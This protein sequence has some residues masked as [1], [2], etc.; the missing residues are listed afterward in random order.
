MDSKFDR[1]AAIPHFTIKQDQQLEAARMELEQVS[2]A[3]REANEMELP[4]G[5]YRVVEEAKRKELN[6]LMESFAAANLGSSGTGKM[7]TARQPYHG[8]STTA[9]RRNGNSR[10]EVNNHPMGRH[11]KEGTIDEDTAPVFASFSTY[12]RRSRTD[13][14]AHP[15]TL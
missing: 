9:R 12:H 1:K 10:R 11:E 6:E 2:A 8:S 7:G 14:H 5:H 13:G 4:E 3:L 15:T